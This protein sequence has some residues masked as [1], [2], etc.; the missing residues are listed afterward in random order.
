MSWLEGV[1]RV[2]EHEPADDLEEAAC[3]PVWGIPPSSARLAGPL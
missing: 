1:N 3:P 2:P